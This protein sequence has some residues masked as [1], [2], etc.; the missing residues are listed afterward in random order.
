[1]VADLGST[2][3][4]VRDLLGIQRGDVIKLRKE[5]DGEI[6]IKVGS[7]QKFY[8]VLGANNNKMAIKITRA[9]EDGEEENE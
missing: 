7:N 8:G 4:T 5:V 2:T 6:D 1:M 9:Y 3:L